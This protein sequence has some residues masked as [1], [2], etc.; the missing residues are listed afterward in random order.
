MSKIRVVI[1]GMGAVTPLGASLETFWE[2]LLA[3]RSGIRRITRFDPAAFACQVAGEVPDFE[4]TEYMPRKEAR[5]LP[6]SAQMAVAAAQQALQDAALPLPLADTAL[7]GVVIGTAMGGVDMID[8]GIQAT[9]RRGPHRVNPFTLP[10]AIPN[11]SA[12]LVA[13]QA[14]FTGPNL[15]ITTACASGSQAVG[16]AVELI[17]SGRIQVAVSG[18]TEALVQ[19]YAIAGF[20]SMH[21]LVTAYNHAPQRASRPFD[22]DRQ[23]FV[24][25]EAA[26]M[27]VLE[28]LEH[29]QA[30]GAHI[31]AEIVGQAA[32][33]DAYHIAAP[34][35]EARGRIQA[36]QYALRDAALVPAQIGYISAHG[37]STR[38]NDL[39]ET[40]AIKQVFGKHAYRIPV[41]SIKSM[42]GHP[43]GAAGALEA[44]ACA[45]A[46]QEQI[47]P[48]TINYENPDPQ[49]DLDYVPNRARTHAMRYALSNS[50]GLGGQNACLVLARWNG[51]S[52]Q[53]DPI[54][55]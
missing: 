10:G 40:Q 5:R 25:S 38:L 35:P 33:T 11:I 23:G 52:A 20:E 31:Y 7:G 50:F 16:V 43:M 41:S 22:A 45:L 55:Q 26:G 2:G 24:F 42:I 34:H 13:R 9:R 14:D 49:C 36:M 27:L 37:T 46:L 1:T 51:A 44:I 39:S 53:G 54:P 21:A 48:P 17:R 29:A 30:R 32:T 18:G 47:I 15:T 6:R 12:F 3:G 28:R 19:D 8:A 4:P